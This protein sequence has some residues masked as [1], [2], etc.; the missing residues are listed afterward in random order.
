MKVKISSKLQ[1]KEGNVLYEV[2]E[3]QKRKMRHALGLDHSKKAY[4]N[5]FQTS[6]DDLDWNDLLDKGLAAK[7]EVGEYGLVWFWLTKQGVE[8]VLGKNISDKQ[9]KEL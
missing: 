2:S 7:G 4:R 5:R 3:E 1:F 6:K 8:F 9:Y